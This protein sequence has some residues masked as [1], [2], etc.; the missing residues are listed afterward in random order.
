M[1]RVNSQIEVEC[2]RQIWELLAHPSLEHAG[3]EDRGTVAN[4]KLEAVQ[5]RVGRKLLGASRTAAGAAIRGD[6]GRKRLEERREEKVL[7][8]RRLQ[9][10]DDS[11]LAKQITAKMKECGGL[12]GGEWICC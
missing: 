6:L 7:Y 10:F 12:V 1:S 9:R 4:R 8:G 5:E 3:G 2:G 11:R